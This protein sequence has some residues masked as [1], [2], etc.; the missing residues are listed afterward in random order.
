MIGLVLGMSLRQLL[1][2]RRTLFLAALAL[3]PLA[4]AVVYRVG[5]GDPDPAEFAA[6]VVLGGLVVNGLLPLAALILGTAALG[7]EIEDGTIAY[8]L[9]KPVARWRILAGKLLASWGATALIVLAGAV[10]SG[11][12]V[13]AGEGEWRIL[14]GF[15][16]AL[17]AGSLAYAALFALL[18]LLTSRALL[19]G[20]AYAFIWEGVITNFAPGVQRL[21]IREYTLG[22]AESA[23]DTPP[24]VFNADLSL[25]LSVALLTVVTAAAAA[26]AMRQLARFE[27]R[28]P[29]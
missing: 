18:S 17:A 21:S 8:L 4:A 20:L 11:A 16:I 29:A 25:A 27:L 1:G 22:I 15:L 13:L 3:V 6:Q 19:V 2:Q 23:A 28:E 10:V 9:T 5:E 24:D 26:F 12:V 14:A 7:N